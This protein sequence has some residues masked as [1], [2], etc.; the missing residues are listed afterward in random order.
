MITLLY[1]IASILMVLGIFFML[2]LTP[3]KITQ[4]IMDILRP[5]NKLRT[6]SED[7]RA[8]RQR[9][10]LY[11]ELQ[12]IRNTMEATGKGKMFPL[13]L[14]ATFGLAVLGVFL[15]L[16]V[17]NVW[18]MPT[19]VFG[20]G[21]LPFLYISSSVE[22]YEK[23]VRNELETALSIITNA[24]IR[25]EDIVQAVEE[26]IDFIKPPLKTVFHAF[27]QDSRIYPST[28]ESIIRLRSRLDDQVFYEWCTTLLQCQDDRTLKDN[29]HPVVSRLTDIRLVNT[30][31]AAVVA[32][33]KTEYW[34]MLGFMI[35][36]IPML[37]LISPGS[38]EILVTEPI[39][40]ALL[41]IVSAVTLF[42]YFRVRKVTKTV[43]YN[44][45]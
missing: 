11:G 9:G 40:K 41:G 31:V 10:G 12:R 24:Y 20:L 36:S 26:T 28:K 25:T 33:A 16:L 30:Q 27:L 44:L 42:S 7:V 2:K 17:D 15:A 8:K 19:L 18:I 21:S 43:D 34:A 29:L 14:T 37:S 1:S 23:S 45:K 13:A 3:V 6:I 22:Y 35:A 39:G 38:L 32:S 4:D 5:A